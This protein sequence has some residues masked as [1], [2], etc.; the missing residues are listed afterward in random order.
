MTVLP[1]AIRVACRSPLAEGAIGFEAAHRVPRMK[2]EPEAINT[3]IAAGCRPPTIACT[4][5]RTDTPPDERGLILDNL[6][7]QIVLVGFEH[8]RFDDLARLERN[9]AR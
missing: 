3:S 9:L 5:P 8:L 6:G 7:V 4:S 2:F 1:V